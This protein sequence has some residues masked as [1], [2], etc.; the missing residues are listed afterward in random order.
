[1]DRPSLIP[2]ICKAAVC[3]V[4]ALT[5]TVGADTSQADEPILQP[6]ESVLQ[7][8]LAP[9]EMP[10]SAESAALATLG[11][12]TAVPEDLLGNESA[13]ARIELG[14]IVLN[15]QDVDG[16]VQGNVATGTTNG[17]NF[18]SESAFAGATG[19]ATA[20]QNT[21]NNVLIQNSTIINVSLDP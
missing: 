19:F 15:E 5:L 7:Q 20:I 16:V 2:A 6:V 9:A 13:M 18:I 14:S 11:A 8:A 17:N 10:A 3:G 12:A 21:G 4:V 1:M